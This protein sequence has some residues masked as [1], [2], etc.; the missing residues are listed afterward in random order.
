MACESLKERIQ[1]A[2]SS[3][4]PR[5]KGEDWGRRSSL[6]DESR[7]GGEDFGRMRCP[8]VAGIVSW[9]FRYLRYFRGLTKS[10]QFRVT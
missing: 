7:L 10:I 3:G 8:S 1:S 9:G 4:N 2:R 5:E 6:L